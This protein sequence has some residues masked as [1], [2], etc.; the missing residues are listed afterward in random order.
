MT[1]SQ[2]YTNTVI[3][4]VITSP[5]IQ[6]G[7][8]TFQHVASSHVWSVNVINRII[9]M[10]SHNPTPVMNITPSYDVLGNL[11]LVLL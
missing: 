5:D 4:T 1:G 6:G 10:A 11:Q 8:T 2:Y 7:L 9:N 3:H